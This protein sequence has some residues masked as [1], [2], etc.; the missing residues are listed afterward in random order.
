MRECR[1]A[2]YGE[3]R[4]KVDKESGTGRRRKRGRKQEEGERAEKEGERKKGRHGRFI[5][6]ATVCTIVHCTVL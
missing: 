6:S 5:G 2:A 4:E 3:N 1:R